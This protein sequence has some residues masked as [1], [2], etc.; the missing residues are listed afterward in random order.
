ML[1]MSP[2]E[3]PDTLED[4]AFANEPETD[5]SRAEERERMLAALGAVRGRLGERVPLVIDWSNP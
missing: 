2:L 5:F 3:R 1:N 4:A